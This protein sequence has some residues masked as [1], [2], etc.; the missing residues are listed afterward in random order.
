MGGNYYFGGNHRVVEGIILWYGGNH[1]LVMEGSFPRWVGI[2]ILEGI[3]LCLKES[4]CDME[5]SIPIWWTEAFPDDK[6]WFL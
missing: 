3:I 1:S 4:S 2:I 5:G 6:E